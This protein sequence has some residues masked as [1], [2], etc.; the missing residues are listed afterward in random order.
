MVTARE[1]R[2]QEQKSLQEQKSK[3][4]RQPATPQ[5]WRLWGP[6]PRPGSAPA[7]APAPPAAGLRPPG[8]C[9]PVPATQSWVPAN[10]PQVG[11]VISRPQLP[12]PCR[13]CVTRRQPFRQPRPP[14]ATPPSAGAGRARPP[15]TAVQRRSPR[16]GKTRTPCDSP[17]PRSCGDLAQQESPDTT[18]RV[19]APEGRR[20]CGRAANARDVACEEPARFSR[21]HA[22]VGAI[23]GPGARPPFLP[24][25]IGGQKEEFDE[26]SQ[27]KE[28]VAS[29]GT[30]GGW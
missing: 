11:L 8:G 12:P 18:D 14:L 25:E 26:L 5:G 2:R 3:E 7:P 17:G 23:A 29:P 10:A 1:L 27:E 28:V 19:T 4:E 6:S 13:A 21:K 16:W 20:L 30:S 15:A 9:R 24:R 22:R